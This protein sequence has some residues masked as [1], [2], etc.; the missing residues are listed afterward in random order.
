MVTEAAGV[1]VTCRLA[2][3]EV[4]EVADRRRVLGSKD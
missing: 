1:E 2:L 4:P 3:P